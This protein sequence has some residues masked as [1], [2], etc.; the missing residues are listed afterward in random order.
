MRPP[1]WIVASSLSLGLI[2]GGCTLVYDYSDLRPAPGPPDAGCGTRTYS[3]AGC[4]SM[5]LE[6]DPDNCG[7][8]GHSCLGGA[9]N[10]GHCEPAL[11]AKVPARQIVLVGDDIYYASDSCFGRI[12]KAGVGEAP[13]L[14]TPAMDSRFAALALDETSAYLTE[15]STTGLVVRA[16]RDGGPTA[17]VLDGLGS[18]AGIAVDGA[19]A[20]VDTQQGLYRVGKDNDATD[21]G[22]T[23]LASHYAMSNVLLDGQ[24]VFYTVA[25]EGMG[26]VG[27][28]PKDGGLDITLTSGIACAP[29]AQWGGDIYT[30]DGPFKVVRIAKTAIE[31]PAELVTTSPLPLFAL[32][33]D[34]DGVYWTAYDTMA[35]MGGIY[36]APLSGGDSVELARAQ[37]W[38]LPSGI[39]LDAEAIYF[40]VDS[41]EIW[42]L[43]R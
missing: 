34:C 21:A 27:R 36:R 24:T 20:Y 26:S 42:K 17:V 38:I 13:C 10:A 40:T 7:G 9:C 23:P 41:R 1:F 6:E 33:V 4:N 15:W 35:V 28:V 31:N 3:D 22:A 37:Q 39:A 2:V 14:A 19:N 25:G 32:T 29:A 5:N 11:V 18:P 16:G 12:S 8:C 43:A 30:N